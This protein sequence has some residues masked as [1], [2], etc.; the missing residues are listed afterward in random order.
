MNG[1]IFDGNPHSYLTVDPVSMRMHEGRYDTVVIYSYADL[2][3]DIGVFVVL[4]C[5]CIIENITVHIRVHIRILSLLQWIGRFLKTVRSWLAST[6]FFWK[7][8]C[9]FLQWSSTYDP[10]RQTCVKILCL[11]DNFVFKFIRASW[12][13]IVKSRVFPFSS[14]PST[15]KW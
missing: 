8:G 6:P 10:F 4:G 3:M 1:V 15:T 12:V 13:A 5:I 11:C 7:N 9:P 14:F 2:D